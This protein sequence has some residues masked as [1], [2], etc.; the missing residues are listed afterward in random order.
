MEDKNTYRIISGGLIF[1]AGAGEQPDTQEDVEVA[2]LDDTGIDLPA[3]VIVFN[4]E[5]HTFEEVINQ[6]M[7]ATGCG[8]NKAETLT[9]EI[10]SKGRAVVYDGDM[11][12][13][14]IV[15]EILEEIDLSTEIQ[16]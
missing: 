6:I 2:E 9:W 15:S 5:W 11:A 10:H 13:C 12:K 14:V 4:D 16:F 7:K 8:Q 3:K 1:T